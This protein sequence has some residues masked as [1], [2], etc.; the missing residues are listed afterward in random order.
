ML[1]FIRVLW[2]NR[3]MKKS[4][5][6]VTNPTCEIDELTAEIETLKADKAKL[7]ALVAYYEEQLRLSKHR[8]FG[9][10]SEQIQVPGCEQL[11]LFNEAEQLADQTAVEP[12]LEQVVG[13]TRHKAA[14]KREQDLG[15]LPTEQ[16]VHELPEDERICPECSELL[17]ACGHDTLRRELVV[18]PAQ[19]KVVEHIQTVYACRNCDQTGTATPM[20]KAPVPAPVIRGSGLCS[21]SLLAHVIHQKYVLALPLYRQEQELKRLGISLSRQTM[22]NWIVYV[23]EKHLGSFIS[24]LRQELLKSEVLHA[25]ET[26]LQVL[27]EEG[28]TAQSKSYM[29]L[30]RTSGYTATP[31]VLYDY[32]QSR[33][34]THPTK[35]LEGFKGFLHTDGY[36]GYHSLPDVTV[37]G[38]WA[39]MRRK[40]DEVL[41]S[42]PP[43]RRAAGTGSQMGLD[44]CNRLFV[45][46]REYTL[47][48]P[49]ERQ[50]RRQAES[51]PVAEEFFA[52][53]TATQP[54]TLPKM[55]FGKAISYAISQ[56]NWLM[57]VYLD[58]RLE[59]SNNRAENSIRPFTVGRKN[60]LFCNTP[61]GAGA[62]AAFYSLIETAKANGLDP[63][64]Y[65]EFLL[66]RIPQLAADALLDDCLPWSEMVQQFC[67]R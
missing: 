47:L 11:T 34:A 54:K 13:H 5:S 57:N 27:R 38:C 20:K 59:L 43:E 14:G 63:F 42:L 22:A 4:A 7:T 9:S 19:V 28:K 2:Y 25:D 32:K 52:W 40:F 36:S 15:A 39:H 10:S 26:T 12:A 35:Y 21:P 48:D 18:I 37:V 23:S 51:K 30:Y 53:A 67:R 58:G 17:H 46:E 16:I 61:A 6:S 41:K 45:L 64:A 66:K 62:S 33:S 29:W 56:K 24:Y 1:G 31:I 60:W 44:Y 50:K 49:D 55:A 8:Q 65:M 3:G